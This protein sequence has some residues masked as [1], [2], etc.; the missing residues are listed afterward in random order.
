[1]TKY[2]TQEGLNKIKK[3]LE[4]LEKVRRKEVSEEIKHTSSQGD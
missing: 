2:L 1:M 4:Y 3:E